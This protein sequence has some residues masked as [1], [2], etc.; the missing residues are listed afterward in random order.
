MDWLQLT[1]TEGTS[2]LKNLLDILQWRSDAMLRRVN[3]TVDP[4]RWSKDVVTP[5]AFYLQRYN[6]LGA[7]KNMQFQL[8]SC[9]IFSLNLVILICSCSG[10]CAS[11]PILWSPATV[12]FQNHSITLDLGDCMRIID[13]GI[14][15]IT[16]QV[17]ELCCNWVQTRPWNRAQPEPWR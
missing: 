11:N 14:I 12:T 4:E 17:L 9:W 13:F 1:L 3:D 15:L 6:N 5:G 16:R 2:H 10:W 7:E 8:A